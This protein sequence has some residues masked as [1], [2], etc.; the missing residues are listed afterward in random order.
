MRRKM[1]RN[2]FEFSINPKSKMTEIRELS[3]PQ[4]M[5]LSRKAALVGGISS[6]IMLFAAMF[7]EFSMRTKLIIPGDAAST[8]TNI[9]ANPSNFRIG[10][11][12]YFLILICDFLMAWAMYNYLKT[13]N[14]SLAIL[15]AW[16]RIIYTTIFG[17]AMTNLMTGFRILNLPSNEELF[18]TSQMQLQALIQFDAFQD[19]WSISFVFFAMHLVLL[20]WLIFKSQNMP[21]LIGIVLMFAGIGYLADNLGKLLLENY[22][23]FAPI[24]MAIMVPASMLGE[25]GLAIWLL[26]KGGKEKKWANASFESAF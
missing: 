8:A 26:W 24:F 19:A 14:K 10:M 12:A 4:D 6:L 1:L 13:S 15:A 5:N 17:F 3:I 21:K 23:E 2:N 18:T 20:G 25:I 11:L 16:A 9:L 22:A 7:A